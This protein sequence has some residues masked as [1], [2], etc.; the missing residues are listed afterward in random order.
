MLYFSILK[1]NQKLKRFCPS[2]THVYRL[3]FS[4]ADAL[5]ITG[6][7]WWLYKV[8]MASQMLMCMGRSRTKKCYLCYGI[9]NSSYCQS[10]IKISSNSANIV[11][12]RFFTIIL[13]AYCPLS[14]QVMSSLQVLLHSRVNLTQCDVIQNYYKWPISF[15]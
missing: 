6:I 11:R 12:I 5:F 4:T 1:L 3:R 14:C 10:A 13:P 2:R 8:A 15:R 7:L 9:S